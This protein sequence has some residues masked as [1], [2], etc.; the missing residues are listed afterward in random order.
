MAFVVEA[1][2]GCV[3]DGAV[4][5][6]D[7]AIGPRVLCFGRTV[8]DIVIG[9]SKFE[10]MSPEQ[11]SVC[12]GFSDQW[13]GRPSGARRSKLNAVISENC[14]DPV[15][16]GRNQPQQELSRYSRGGSF[17]QFDE[18]ELRRPIDGDEHVQLTLLGAHLGNVD[19][20]V[21][22][23]IVFELLLVRLVA[24]NI[25]QLADTVTLQAAMQR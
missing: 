15:G 2:D 18:D 23:R 25:R 16:H 17:V 10:G 20:E 7:L 5:P 4:H 8:F 9:A 21:A 1:L 24:F 13:Y 14:V 3:L 22:D 12:D 6:L 11:F 19:V